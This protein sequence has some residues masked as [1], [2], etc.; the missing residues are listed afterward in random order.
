MVVETVGTT[1]FQHMA[2]FIYNL[3]SILYSL[4]SF[5]YS[6]LIPMACSSG[7]SSVHC[8]DYLIIDQYHIVIDYEEY[9]LNIGVD[10]RGNLILSL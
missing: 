8:L 2:T 9:E 3:F 1:H 6:N 7:W 10:Y 4:H 5:L